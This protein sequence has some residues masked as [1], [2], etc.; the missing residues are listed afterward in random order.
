[1]MLLFFLLRERSLALG[2]GDLSILD[3]RAVS[4]LHRARAKRKMRLQEMSAGFSERQKTE[5]VSAKLL[6]LFLVA[7]YQ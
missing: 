4:P 5:P 2:G 6:P 1:M 3:P 7:S